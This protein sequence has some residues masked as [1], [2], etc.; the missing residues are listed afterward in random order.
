[1]RFAAL[2]LLFLSCSASAADWGKT[3][4]VLL[5]TALGALALDWNQTRKITGPDHV[6]FLT[7]TSGYRRRSG[8]E[9]NPLLG[10]HPSIGTVNR[11]FVL[12][13]LGTAGLAYVLPPFYRRAFLGGLI[14]V[15]S[16]FVISNESAGVHISF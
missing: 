15:E 8:T 7:E 5:G 10:K 9:S 3:D 11:Y 6:V 14:V 13:M 16:A 4:T 12:S 2:A 1:M